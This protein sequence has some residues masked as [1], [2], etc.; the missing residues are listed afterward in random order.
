MITVLGAIAAFIAIMLIWQGKIR[1]DLPSFFKPT[2]PL[3]TGVFGVY[4]FT[5]KQGTGKTYS[6]TKYIAKNA[7]ER[8]IYSNLTLHGIDYRP[9]RDVQHLLSLKDE[10]N[11]YIVFDE[12]FTL[13][14]DKT[15]PKDIREDLMEFLSQQRKMKNILLTT[16][17]EW[18]ELSMTF[19]RFVRIQI[20]CRTIPL[21]NFG[22]ILIETYVDATAMKW[23][24]N[25]NEYVAPRISMKI[26]KYEKKYMIAYN[27]YERIGRLERRAAAASATRGVQQQRTHRKAITPM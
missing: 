4:C 20:E 15:I 9:I 2:L 5:G 12:M 10:K 24:Q 22:G 16:V 7:E 27:T 13:L 6:L 19:R 25:E 17:Q 8:I 1:L 26:S 21:G 3:D 14:G 18:L 11:L 23:D